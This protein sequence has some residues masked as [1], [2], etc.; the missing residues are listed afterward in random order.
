RSRVRLTAGLSVWFLVRDISVTMINRIDILVVGLVLGI[1]AA[2]IFA[3]GAKAAQLLRKG[4][5]PLG[6]V[7]FPHA[8]A[9]SRRDPGGLR[10]LLVDGTRTSMLI[11]TPTTIVLCFLAQPLVRVWVGPGYGEAARVLVVLAIGLGVS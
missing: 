10:S 5:P 9:L 11:G 1:K 6:L 8:S 3:I 7:F 4:L 2:A